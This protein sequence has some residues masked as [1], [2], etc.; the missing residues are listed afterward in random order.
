MHKPVIKS[1]KKS[2]D[3][4]VIEEFLLSFDV[5]IIN[6]AY[7][8]MNQQQV[9]RDWGV[10]TLV[11]GNP[12][13]KCSKPLKKGTGSCKHKAHFVLENG[14]GCCAS[15][16]D[17]ETDINYTRNITVENSTDYE[18]KKKLFHDLKSINVD[19]V[20][21]ILIEK[22]PKHAREKIKGIA[23]SIFDYYVMNEGAQPYSYIDFIDAK[24]KLTVYEGPPISCHLK[25]QYARNKWY[26]LKYC[27]W[28]LESSV[29]WSEFIS[30]H[31]KKDDLAD[32]FL[33]GI[34]YLKYGQHGIK[35]PITSGHQKLVF[36]ENNIIKYDK[37][38]AYKP[39]KNKN[40]T[41]SN[42]KYLIQ[43]GDETSEPL[44][45]ALEFFFGQCDIDFINTLKK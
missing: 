21:K 1:K 24:N 19:G 15:H 37:I 9:I 13:L 8:V 42:I 11:D 38:R 3:P 18:L 33:Q 30:K 27:Q 45:Q 25:T 36:K 32:C 5:G 39:K 23:H 12:K 29:T 26:G 40:L 6:L 7:C 20:K 17:H 4:P 41:L 28:F 31:K 43:H 44:K 14:K 16:L 10:I 34:W 35:A 2:A 22:Q